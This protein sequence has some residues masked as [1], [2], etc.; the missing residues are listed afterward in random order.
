MI[1]AFSHIQLKTEFDL[2]CM[3]SAVVVVQG[4]ITRAL[5]WQRHRLLVK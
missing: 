2:I 5:S 3:T 1:N 4:L